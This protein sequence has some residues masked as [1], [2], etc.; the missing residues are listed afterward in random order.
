MARASVL[1]FTAQH[2]GSVTLPREAKLL[3]QKLA[4]HACG[5]GQQKPTQ[6]KERA[7]LPEQIKRAGAVVPHVPVEQL[8]DQQADQKLEPRDDPAAH[9]APLKY[10]DMLVFFVDAIDPQKCR[11]ARQPHAPMRKAAEQDLD[12]T[13]H[14]GAERIDAKKFPDPFHLITAYSFA[15]G[16][17]GYTGKLQEITEETK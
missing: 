17:R 3:F 4:Q 7:D 12:Q 9:Q 16:R 2:G 5:K 13:I 15:A 14:D 10:R 11:A 1:V 8:V 6:R